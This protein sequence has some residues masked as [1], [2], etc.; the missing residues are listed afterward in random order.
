MT[1]QVADMGMFGGAIEQMCREAMESMPPV[2]LEE[3]ERLATEQQ[4]RD[5]QRAEQA[6]IDQATIA[7]LKEEYDFVAGYK[8]NL[9]GL[10]KRGCGRSGA[11]KRTV[12]HALSLKDV[13]CGRISRKAETF[14][15]GV[16]EGSFGYVTSPSAT[17]SCPRCVAIV[18]KHGLKACSDPILKRLQKQ[19]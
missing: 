10:T 2:S 13:S 16:K 14:L 18:E 9:S 19:L 11:M 15:C 8:L 17:A 6:E 7:R 5:R 1:L 3:Q 4:D 12:Y